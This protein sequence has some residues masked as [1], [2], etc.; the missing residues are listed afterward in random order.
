MQNNY[1]VYAIQQQVDGSD[2][3]VRF[4][5]ALGC[6]R[7]LSQENSFQILP[8]AQCGTLKSRLMVCTNC[9]R[10]IKS[11]EWGQFTPVDN[12]V[13]CLKLIIYV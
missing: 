13:L 7:A 4:V 3:L 11:V 2:D 10:F 1:V 6:P 8:L 9:H 12:L 5:P